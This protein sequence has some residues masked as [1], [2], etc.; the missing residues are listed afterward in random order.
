MKTLAAI[1][2]LLCGGVY[3]PAQCTDQRNVVTVIGVGEIKAVPDEVDLM[4]SIENSAREMAQAKSENQARLKRVLALMAEFQIDAKDYQTTNL[5]IQPHYKDYEAAKAL[6]GYVASVD[7]R[8]TLRDI[9]KLTELNSRAIQ[10]GA[11]SFQQ[12]SYSSSQ[13]AKHRSG[14]RAIA[15]KAARDKA[16][17]LA[18]QL[19]QKIGKAFS[20]TEV[21]A[22]VDYSALGKNKMAN[23]FSYSL[24][25]GTGNAGV[26]PITETISVSFELQ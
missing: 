24:G 19:G 20:I 8:V 7:I 5:S 6:L 2:F 16:E 21:Q 17:F 23:A 4:I 12:T 1:L 13:V 26:I 11:T 14:A 25:E 15:M 18:A 10:A 3:A 9:K 22:G